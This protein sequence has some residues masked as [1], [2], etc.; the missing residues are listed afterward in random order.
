MKTFLTLAVG[1]LIGAFAI[2]AS[3]ERPGAAPTVIRGEV[4][5][6][7]SGTKLRILTDQQMFRG[8]EV[9]LGELT[10]AP[11]TDSGDHVHGATETFY[12]LEG[13][14]EHVVNG[15]SI[16]LTP[17]MVG[18]VRPPDQVRH[19]TGPAGARALVV[20]A[21]AG[22]AARIASRWQRIQQP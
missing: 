22:E 17:G 4:Y 6:S 9:E 12:V 11:N 14:L 8:T 2:G 18:T 19:K 16:K 7:A 21:P 13:E 10:F 20:W 15:R 5:Q 3:A 1:V